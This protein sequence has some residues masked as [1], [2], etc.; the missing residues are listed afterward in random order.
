MFSLVGA[1]EL[2]EGKHKE[3]SNLFMYDLFP[4]PSRLTH[5]FPDS[6]D[7]KEKDS[8]FKFYIFILTQDVCH[9]QLK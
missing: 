9:R 8:V 4:L 7:V 2:P 3:L 6:D 1:H 5:Y